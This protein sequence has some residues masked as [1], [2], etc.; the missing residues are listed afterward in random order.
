MPRPVEVYALETYEMVRRAVLVD[1]KSIRE[2]ARE[3]GIHRRT[4]A[5]MVKEA[6]PP[7]YTLRVPRPR[8]QLGRFV[9]QI[10]AMLLENVALP[11]K[12]RQNGHRIFEHLRDEFGYTGCESQVRAQVARLK[13]AR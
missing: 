8:P 10:E 3:F 2:A 5:K 11:P 9:P 7:G 6:R 13:G 12:Q 1:G 4:V